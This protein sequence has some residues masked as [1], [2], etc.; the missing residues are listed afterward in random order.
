MFNLRQ[1][2]SSFLTKTSIWFRQIKNRKRKLKANEL[3]YRGVSY[4]SKPPVEMIET[5][6]I[7]KYRG[8][9]VKIHKLKKQLILKPKNN[10]QYRGRT[11]SYNPIVIYV[12]PELEISP[13]IPNNINENQE[14]NNDTIHT[15]IDNSNE[16]KNNTTI[17]LIDNSNKEETNPDI[18]TIDNDNEEE[19]PPTIIPEP[20]LLIQ[21]TPRLRLRLEK[22]VFKEKR[23]NTS[24]EGEICTISISSEVANWLKNPQNYLAK[25]YHEPTP[26]K[27]K[28]L[29]LMVKKKPPQHPLFDNNYYLAWA[30]YILL[31]D[32]S[33][34]I[35]GFLMQKIPEAKQLIEVYNPEKRLILNLE[36]YWEIDWKF[37]HLTAM[38]IASIIQHLHAENYVIGDMK[39]DNILVNQEALPSIIDTDSF[40]ITDPETDKIYHCNVGSEGFTPP[41][42]L[43]KEFSE[44][45]QNNTHDNFRLAVII[46]YLLFGEHP[47]SGKWIGSEE[48]PEIDELI[49]LN[50]WPYAPNSLIQSSFRNIPLEIVHPDI[51]ECFLRCFNDGYYNPILRP[52][53]SDWSRALKNGLDDLV[54]CPQNS[55]H[56]YSQTYGRCYWCERNEHLRVDI[57][58]IFDRSR[59]YRKLLALLQEKEW[60]KAD[61]ETKYIMLKI[62]GRMK[63]G[64]LDESAIKKFPIDDLKTID[65]FWQN[66]SNQHFGFSVQKNIYLGTNNKPGEFNR[67]TYNKF[68]EEVGWRDKKIW[69]NY[70]DLEFSLNA[71]KGHLPFCCSAFNVCL[72]SYISVK[73]GNV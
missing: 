33:G 29:E 71:P 24:G 67:E 61:L 37:L 11:Y 68:G 53:A 2:I 1:L 6:V 63:K 8:C 12:E 26:E 64:W 56:W 54:Q 20:E 58:D 43:G 21:S 70:R 25:I 32:V 48:R 51:K 44:I 18:S 38:R 42:L 39:Q 5:E 31:E 41:E 36:Y 30:E 50:Y 45:T 66:Y 49:G 59:L 46:Y 13:T 10:L 3:I 28:K 16:G 47:F 57:F 9:D 72:V 34:E 15:F 40:Q 69:K 19:K 17:S 22:D 27:G 7:G 52:F 35:V 23:I 73:L 14:E 62:T 4:E 60:K 55:N 65:E